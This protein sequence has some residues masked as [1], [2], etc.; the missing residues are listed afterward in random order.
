[1]YNKIVVGIDQSYEQTGISIAVDGG[2]LKKVTSI[3]LKHFDTHKEK[4]Y[5]LHCVLKHIILTNQCKTKEMIFIVERIRTITGKK[6]NLQIRPEYLKSIGA[7]IGSIVDLAHQYGIIV[8]SVDTR[9]WKSK[10]LGS[11]KTPEKYSH[12]PKPEKMEAVLFI[13]KLGFDIFNRDKNGAIKRYIR[14]QY[15]DCVKYN[16][17]ACDSGC[18]ALY[19]F[20]PEKQQKL[21]VEE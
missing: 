16:D 18:I 4:R 10:V 17:D 9:S 5:K 19:G 13:Q 2:I 8:Y 12:L 7:L 20:I 15:K 21:K 11:S 14:G 3:N 1:M 6:G